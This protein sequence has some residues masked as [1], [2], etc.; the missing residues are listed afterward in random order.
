MAQPVA[1]AVMVML[2][3][4]GVMLWAK[5]ALQGRLEQVLL[6][7][8]QGQTEQQQRLVQRDRMPQRAHSASTALQVRLVN[9]G[10]LAHMVKP[11]VPVWRLTRTVPRD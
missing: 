10:V 5:L 8:H 9:Q 2:G 7:A 3:V 4:L 6:T 1:L 11:V